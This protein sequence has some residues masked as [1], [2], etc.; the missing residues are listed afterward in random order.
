MSCRYLLLVFG[1]FWVSTASAQ[2]ETRLSTET[3]RGFEKFVAGVEPQIL[4]QAHSDRP[5]SFIGSASRDRVKK[6]EVVLIGKTAKNGFEVPDGLVHDWAGAVFLPG[7]TVKKAAEVLQAFAR[8]KD[9][10]PEII[11]SKLISKEGNYAAGQWLLLKKKIITVVMRAELDSRFTEVSPEHG[12][13][14]SRS[15]PIIEIEDFKT[16]A[17]KDY[18]PGQGHGFLWRFNGYWNLYH[19][20][21][22]VYAECRII[23]LSRDVPSGLGF[24]VSPFIRSMPKDSLEATLKNTREA[25]RKL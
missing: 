20:D 5:L 24:I 25:V 1:C 13:I 11:E 14:V 17:E 16:A 8:H 12:F 9:W 7:A 3:I 22:G 23:S 15:K 4:E 2:L 18:P 6:G 10:Y 19:A 21:G